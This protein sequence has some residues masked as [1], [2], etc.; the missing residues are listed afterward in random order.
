MAGASGKSRRRW[1]RAVRGMLLT[2][3]PDSLLVRGLVDNPS[4]GLSPALDRSTT[5]ENPPGGISPYGRGHGPVA[6][7][8]EALLGALEGAE[9]T[10]FASCLLYT[11]DAAD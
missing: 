5:Y 3:E 9:A 10:V 4:H 6:K 11:S 2:V 8:A 1:C 7:E